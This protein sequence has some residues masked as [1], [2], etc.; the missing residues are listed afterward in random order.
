MA[1]PKRNEW[2]KEKMI[3][4][5]S[6]RLPESVHIQVAALAAQNVRSICGQ[7][8]FLVQEA[9]KASDAGKAGQ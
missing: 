1:K 7:V 6:L 3:A 9:L 2:E 4:L 5:T 8:V